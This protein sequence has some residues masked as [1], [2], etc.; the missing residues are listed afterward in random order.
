MSLSRDGREAAALLHRRP[1][2]QSWSSTASMCTM[3]VYVLLY[4][5]LN[6]SL[7][8]FNKLVFKKYEFNFPCIIMFFHQLLLYSVLRSL[9]LCDLIERPSVQTVNNITGPVII[10]GL[11]FGANIVTNNASLMFVSLGLNQCLKASTPLLMIFVAYFVEGKKT[12]VSMASSAILTSVGSFMVALHNPGFDFIGVVLVMAS[13]FLAAFQ[14]AAAS[15]TMRGQTNLVVHTTMYSALVVCFFC[16]PLILGLELDKFHD[17]VRRNSLLEC[18]GVLF[19]GGSMA[20]GYLLVING[21][22]A[23]GGTVYLTVLGNA[24]LALVVLAS[25]YI[26]EEQLTRFNMI[27]IFV[28]ILGF[29]CYNFA[30]QKQKQ[31]EQMQKEVQK[32]YEDVAWEDEEAQ[33]FL[34]GKGET[35]SDLKKQREETTAKLSSEHDA[36]EEQ[37]RAC[38]ICSLEFAIAFFVFSMAIALILPA[39][40]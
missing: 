28:T 9:T 31:R 18:L 17:Y 22:I 37:R 29:I 4:L 36:E 6:L 16:L 25:C 1:A 40:F 13:A 7:N 11:L 30:K 23:I 2:S 8:L 26:F 14:Y 20:T 34:H 24:K 10:V 39:S 21:L 27:G 35:N 32:I 33:S 38:C 3:M 15:V 5:G 12:T 19:V